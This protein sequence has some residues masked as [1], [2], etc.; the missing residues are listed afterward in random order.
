MSTH[1]QSVY[2]E[3]NVCLI[4]KYRPISILSTF[5][6]IIEKHVANSLT[7]YLNNNNLISDNQFGFRQQ[8]STTA[9]ILKLTDYILD[10]FDKETILYW[11]LSGP[12]KSF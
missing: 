8:R 3:L 12:Y 1:N 10:N 7:S 6:K 5:S 4:T 2:I 11:N 9:A